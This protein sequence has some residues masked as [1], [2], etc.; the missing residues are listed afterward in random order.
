MALTRYPLQIVGDLQ[1]LSAPLW[2]K[3]LQFKRTGDRAPRCEGLCKALELPRTTS[4]G[5]YRVSD[6]ARDVIC[7]LIL[8]TLGSEKVGDPQ[9]RQVRVVNDIIAPIITDGFVGVCCKSMQ[10]LCT[11]V[12]LSILQRSES[13]RHL[14]RDT[15]YDGLV[16]PQ[17]REFP[18]NA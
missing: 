14:P 4:G 15:K 7:L 18:Y 2:S 12:K 5:V 13:D 6:E 9:A 11:T 3:V 1:A 10:K 17:Y 16:L 8:S